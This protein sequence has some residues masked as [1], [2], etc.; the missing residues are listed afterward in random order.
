MSG[1]RTPTSAW[2]G[3]DE[4]QFRSKTFRT[5]SIQKQQISLSY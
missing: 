5:N 3:F 1:K 2:N 4:S